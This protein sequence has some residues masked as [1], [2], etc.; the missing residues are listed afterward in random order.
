[1]N[2]EKA[3]KKMSHVADIRDEIHEGIVRLAGVRAWSDTRESWIA[4]A[5]RKAGLSPRM[6][7][8]LFY[9]E[10]D[11]PKWSVVA[12]VRDALRRFDEHQEANARDELQSLRDR[13]ATLET[14]L[15][16]MASPDADPPGRSSR[17]PRHGDCPMD[18]QQEE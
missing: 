1:M 2:S 15:A 5:A 13:I 12:A 6:A 4:R 18:F 11:D 10:I 16:D 14:A 7:R 17:T 9:R 3:S 8:S